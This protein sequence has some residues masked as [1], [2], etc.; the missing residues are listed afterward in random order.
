M[1]HVCIVILIGKYIKSQKAALATGCCEG[2]FPI[3]SL[4]HSCF[5]AVVFN[6]HLRINTAT[7]R[8]LTHIQ[9]CNWPVLLTKVSCPFFAF[10]WPPENSVLSF[11]FK[12]LRPVK[13]LHSVCQHAGNGVGVCFAFILF[14]EGAKETQQS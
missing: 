9:L 14:L 5:Y 6:R 1:F 12:T 3:T 8:Y 7:I 13:L 11:Y 4:W 2:L 10:F